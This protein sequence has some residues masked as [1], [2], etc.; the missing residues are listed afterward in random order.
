M[1]GRDRMVTGIQIFREY[2][3]NFKEQYTII[4]G[5]ACDLLMTDAGLDFRQ[6]VDIDIA[7][8]KDGSGNTTYEA[9]RMGCLFFWKN[10]DSTKAVP[11]GEEVLPLLG[12][13]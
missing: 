2:F 9:S 1:K 12:H 11:P 5:F 10:G 13:I 3:R 8:Q 7:R 4:G 6:T